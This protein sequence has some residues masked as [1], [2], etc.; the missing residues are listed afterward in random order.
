MIGNSIKSASRRKSGTKNGWTKPYADFPLSFHP[1]SGRLYKKIRG[2]RHYFGYAHS[3]QAAVE[4]YLDQK[5]D[6]Q[7]GRRPRSND[8]GRDGPGNEGNGTRRDKRG[9][10]SWMVDDCKARD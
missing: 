9:T 6:L 4:K 2:K 8:D 7:A 3:W 1:P 5:D 10:K